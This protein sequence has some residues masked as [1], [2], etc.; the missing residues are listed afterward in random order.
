MEFHMRVGNFSLLIP[1]GVEKDSGHIALP[2]GKQY[3]LKAGNHAGSRCDAEV[4]I[5]GKKIG[6]FRLDGYDYLTL[7]RSPDDSGRFTFYADGTADAE[8][9]GVAA[10]AVPD[11]GLIQVKFVP[12]RYR[13]RV[14]RPAAMTR[15]VGGPRGQSLGGEE[16]TSDRL[17]VE[18]SAPH[19]FGTRSVEKTTGGITG[20]SGHSDQQFTAVG[21]IDRDEDQAVTISVRLILRDDGPRPLKAAAGM[22]NPVPAPV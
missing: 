22:G 4:S 5:D 20:L 10:V 7:E 17:L 3:T 14:V 9:A 12:E 19:S 13:E 16:Y 21:R 18:G 6:T 1:E 2:H 15:S 11:R 8:R